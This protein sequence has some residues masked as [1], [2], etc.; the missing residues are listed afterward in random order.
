MKLSI[1]SSFRAKLLFSLVFVVLIVGAGSII[2]GITIINDKIIGQAYDQVQNDLRTA[3]Y[4]YDNQIDRIYLFVKHLS[5]LTYL[6]DAVINKDRRFIY[7]KLLEVK[8]EAGL[9]ILNIADPNGKI[10]VRAGN[11]NIFGDNVDKEIC[12]YLTAK[13][14]QKCMGSVVISRESL[15]KDGEELAKRAYCDVIP[16][17]MAR[18]RGKKFEERGLAIMA[19]MPIFHKGSFAGVIYGAKLLNNN[20]DFVD[21]IQKL[22][23]QNEMYGGYQLGTA[24]IFLDD[25]RISTNVKRQDGSRAVGTQVSEQVYNKV[26][27]KGMV[28]IDEAFVVN[29]W[30]ISGY[31]PIINIWDEVIGILYVGIL[32][33]KYNQILKYTIVYFMLVIFITLVIATIISISLINGI[34]TPL[35]NLVEAS[36]EI[37]AGNYDKKIEI[38]AKDEMGY[39]CY[40]FN[41]MIDSIAEKDRE[42]LEQTEK[43]IGQSEKLASLGRIASGI[44][45]EINNPLTGVLTCS[46]LLLE[47]LKNTEYKEDLELIINETLRCRQIVKGILDFARESKLEKQAININQVIIDVFSIL[48][49][50]VNFQNIKI[51]KNLSDNLPDVYIDVIQMKSVINNLAVNASDAMPNGGYLIVTTRYNNEKNSV[52]IEVADTGTGISEENL[53]HIFDP[54]FTTKDPGEGTGLGLSVTY[55]IIK[56]HNGSI[57][58][59]SRVNV[60]TK[61]TIELP[62][63]V[64]AV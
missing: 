28:W 13:K 54:F 45:H 8:E 4:I 53:E 59:E 6:Q 38:T 52:I 49:K 47:D 44:A 15:L 14:M 23:F 62:V 51:S 30:Y 19:A 5:T 18:Q 34:I 37:A 7:R 56:R 9:D 48:E 22:V 29:N 46:S 26:F 39:L 57:S 3:Q 10:I 32:K 55:G 64:P 40:A 20:F 25:V 50:L 63:E 27:K 33:E 21:Q 31:R 12:V 43:K 42:L 2:I 1:T 41:K 60:G 17:P 36:R 35:R 58:I 61:F 11:Y 16:T 24:T